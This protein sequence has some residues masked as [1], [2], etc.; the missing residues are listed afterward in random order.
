M[1]YGRYTNNDTG[2][3]LFRKRIL[4]PIGLVLGLSLAGAAVN[5]SVDF[6]PEGSRG[7]RAAEIQKT[8]YLVQ[9]DNYIRTR[10]P[11]IP[12]HER[13]SLAAAILSNA[14]RLK[15]FQMDG[16]TVDPVFFLAAMVKVESTFYRTARSRSGALG[17]MQLMPLTFQGMTAR[18]GRPL[19]AA[20]LFET[21]INIFWGVSY[22]NEL[23]VD[24]GQPRLVVLAYNAGPNNVRRGLY[25]PS[26]WV[27]V[28]SAYREMQSQR[29]AYLARADEADG[30]I[31]LGTTGAE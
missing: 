27:N 14:P 7:A 15:P 11:N 6:E 4:I 17:Y 12:V 26:Y 19:P 1:Q 2:S 25:D 16:Q 22:L 20:R 30:E 18:E 9:L 29:S 10:N 21:E 28:A 3:F 8:A 13:K 31:A 23:I 5:A 24:L